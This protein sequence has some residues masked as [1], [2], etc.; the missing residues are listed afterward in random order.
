MKISINPFR[1]ERW[2]KDDVKVLFDI[3]QLAERKGID[4]INLTEHIIMNSDADKDYPYRDPNMKVRLFD[5]ETPFL[6]TLTQMAALAAVTKTMRLSTGVLLA[7]LRPAVLLAKQVATVDQLSGGRVDLGIG[8]GWLK[9]EYDADGWQWEGRFGRMVEIA[10]AC[11]VLWTQ[12]PAAFHG[13]HINF[14]DVYCK[15][16]P[17]QKGGVPLWFGVAPTDRNIERMAE[18]ADGYAPLGPPLD[19][20]SAAVAKIKKRMTELGRDTS[21]F[22]LRLYPTPVVKNGRNDLDATLET[23]PQLLDAGATHIDFLVATYCNTYEE[24]EPFLD[25]LI[26]AKAKYAR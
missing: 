26:A 8:V 7:P 14:D 18:V 1:T 24:Y 11:K 20:V 16:F 9:H 4:G 21:N 10:K 2:F 15:P 6:E 22:K 3:V 5:P 17:A 19:V 23:L 13:K 25:K 12:A